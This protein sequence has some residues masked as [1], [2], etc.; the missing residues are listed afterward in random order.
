LCSQDIIELIQQSHRLHRKALS[1]RIRTV[2]REAF[3]ELIRQQLTEIQRMLSEYTLPGESAAESVSGLIP[4]NAGFAFRK[5]D[6]RIFVLEEEP[7]VRTILTEEYGPITLALPY[8]VFVVELIGDQHSVTDVFFRTQKLTGIGASLYQ[9]A[10]PNVVN[11]YRG[12]RGF[13]ICFGTT[14]EQGTA[15]QLCEAVRNS[16]W[17]TVFRYE[18]YGR[19]ASAAFDSQDA[20]V[21]SFEHWA[22]ETRAQG[23]GFALNAKW[24]PVVGSLETFVHE[25]LQV[26]NETDEETKEHLIDR[27]DTAS[28]SLATGLQAALLGAVDKIPL[29]NAMIAMLQK[30]A[31]ATYRLYGSSVKAAI[32]ELIKALEEN[33]DVKGA[34]VEELLR[35]LLSDL[36]SWQLEKTR[37]INE[38]MV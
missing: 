11:N 2:G 12:R 28:E 37:E 34:H 23:I 6:K 4:G 38:R 25:R 17:N 20:T 16:F 29:D 1:E 19:V 32:A 35:M 9:A 26:D 3:V 18:H 27:I 14:F 10:L 24:L 7:N 8:V 33:H 31:E 30:H 15:H 22:S 5:G 36:P 21:Q 13:P